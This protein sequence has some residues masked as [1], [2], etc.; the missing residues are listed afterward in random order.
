MTE[1]GKQRLEECINAKNTELN[2]ANCE[3]TNADLQGLIDLD[4][5]EA[6]DLSYNEIDDLSP[7]LPFL[8]RGIEI[9]R[10]KR[11]KRGINVAENPVNLSLY[12]AIKLG[13]QSVIS[14][15]KGF[16]DIHENLYNYLIKKEDLKFTLNNNQRQ[17][18][19]GYWF[20]TY[21]Q[22]LYFSLW[23]ETTLDGTP[24]IFFA[25]EK[26]GHCSLRLI[27]DQE[28]K[29]TFL[30]ELAEA[31]D[32]YLA[33]EDDSFSFWMKHYK[34][35]MYMDSVDI[36]LK[37]DKKIIDAFIKSG[38]S[39]IFSFITDKEFNDAKK[40]IEKE[41]NIFDEEESPLNNTKT[42]ID[43]ENIILKSLTFKNISLFDEEYTIQFHRNLTCFIGLNGTGKTSILR[44]IAL[45]FTGFEQNDLNTTEE[46]ISLARNLQHLLHIKGIKK[47]AKDY[48][49]EGGYIELNYQV[50]E[51]ETT[52]QNRVLL[53][54]ENEEPKISDDSNSEFRN[55]NDK[56]FRSLFLAFPQLHGSSKPRN[57]PNKPNI[58][59]V[60]PLLNNE[61]D[62]RFEAFGKWLRG[63]NAKANEKKAQGQ[64]NPPESKLLDTVFKIVSDVV[65][66][67]IKVHK[68]VVINKTD[69]IIWVQLGENSKP[70]VLELISQGYNNVFGWIG[71]FMMRLVE[72]TVEDPDDIAK[73]IDFSQ[74]PAIVL[75]DEIDTYLHPDWQYTILRTLM[76]YFPKVQFIVTT[77]SPFALTSVH[78]D[79]MY[80]YN[81]EKEQGTATIKEVQ[82]NLYG[83]DANRVTD[84]MSEERL[85]EIKQ[86]FVELDKLIYND[87]LDKAEKMLKEDFV[88]IEK[89][90]A[91]I[92]GAKRLISTKRMFH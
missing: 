69:D 74:L 46:K 34:G 30:S 12:R 22:L 37:R 38:G 70:I 51:D 73:E 7:L 42:N 6:I 48:P 13:R 15:Y 84:V 79:Q 5:L 17:L 75:I 54:L 65:G 4:F 67:S 57:I 91:D 25:I 83:A 56:F 58:Y 87:E 11:R 89:S 77:H 82:E 66:E 21:R 50:G 47:E 49:S 64:P 61:P 88:G 41:K 53:T 8:E 19:Q 3:V 1:E 52:Y 31:L 20:K 63:L 23:K 26:S 40:A 28:Y 2:L 86:K 16:K 43:Y 81:L 55:F 36:F 68:I 29:K 44:G 35:T 80:I 92:V 60:L 76:K 24:N 78:H 45:A 10:D 33:K 9:F 85:P 18:K 39:D 62:N 14:Y 32:M 59:D 27:V 71:Y 72:A 90:D